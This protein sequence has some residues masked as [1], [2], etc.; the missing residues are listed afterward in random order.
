MKLTTTSDQDLH[1][2]STGLKGFRIFSADSDQMKRKIPKTISGICNQGDLDTGGTHWVAF[3]NGANQKYTIYYD[4]FGQPPDP[5]LLRYLKTSGK[6]V[7]GLSSIHQALDS[8]A[9]GYYC[10]F[11]LK[12]MN[13]GQS[14]AEFL[15]QFSDNEKKN[16]KILSTFFKKD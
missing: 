3:Y 10:I 15:S 13:K 6:Q 16:E 5:R 11:F 2:L 7:I 4:S 8:K 14:P 1:Q 9:C 12:A